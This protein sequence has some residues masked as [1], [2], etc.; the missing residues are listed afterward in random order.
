[1]QFKMTSRLLA[2]VFMCVTAGCA[3]DETQPGEGTLEAQEANAESKCVKKFDGITSCAT[4]NAALASSERGLA[5]TGLKNVKSD[6]LSSTFGRAASWRQTSQMKLGAGG[7]LQFDARSG[8]QVVSTLSIL[9]GREPNSARV[10][11][12]FTGAPGGSG[13]RMNIYR[14]GVLQG[15][16]SNPANAYISFTN[17]RD[18]LRWLVAVADF[19]ELDIIWTKTG[20][21]PAAPDNVG[22]CGWRLNTGKDTF[23]VTLADGKVI[24]GDTMEFVEEIEDGHYP[25][26]GFTGIDVKAAGEGILVQSETFVP[27]K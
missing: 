12:I 26:T 2:A 24:T 8:D 27:A 13:Y 19:Y 4:G 14:D 18:F 10:A 21:K 3:G 1:M 7:A 22:A 20:D 5:V 11:P 16:Q 9:P 25:Y 6:G 15:T 17:W 23:N